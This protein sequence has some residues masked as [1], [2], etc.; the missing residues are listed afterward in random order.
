[1]S[2]SNFLPPLVCACDSELSK[3]DFFGVLFS[4]GVNMVKSIVVS[5][6]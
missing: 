4:F 1:M 5:L 3:L 6:C 2:V